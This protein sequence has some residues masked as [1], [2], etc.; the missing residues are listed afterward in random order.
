MA[1]GVIVVNNTRDSKAAGLLS[2]IMAYKAEDSYGLQEL[3][4]CSLIKNGVLRLSSER[5]LVVRICA[6]FRAGN[7]T[8]FEG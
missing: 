2:N 3:G 1:N 5:A 7:G 8:F 4:L 6:F